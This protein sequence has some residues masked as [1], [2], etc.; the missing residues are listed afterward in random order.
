MDQQET[1][2]ERIKRLR[3]NAKLSQEEL[4]SKCSLN[5]N[6]IYKY[7]KGTTIP[8]MAQI[9]KIADALKVKVTDLIEP[10]LTKS[11]EILRSLIPAKFS[12]ED[13]AEESNIP[14]NDLIA[15]YNN[16]DDYITKSFFDLF[17]FLGYD[18]NEISKLS[19]ECAKFLAIYEYD[20]TI[21]ERDMMFQLMQ[22]ELE[23]MK[24]S[25]IASQHNIEMY[26]TTQLISIYFNSVLH[27][28]ENRF[29]SEDESHAIQ[30]HFQEFL[31][32]YKELINSIVDAKMGFD[33]YKKMYS[34]YNNKLPNP[35]TD[36]QIK[37]QYF[38]QAIDRQLNNLASYTFS[39]TYLLGES[40]SHDN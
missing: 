30:K 28:S 19:V 31:F 17:T 34:E 38:K 13:L 1:L 25:N 2:G 14:I 37:E 21:P 4:A 8:K 11:Q 15:I 33:N 22:S 39:I 7:E 10:K 26:N 5:R 20:N 40:R 16:T 29:L 36:S 3:K 23:S 35:L 24:V 9:I 27:W 18:S 12:I 6:S 32:R